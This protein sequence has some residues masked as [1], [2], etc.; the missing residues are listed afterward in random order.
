MWAL[1]GSA[2]LPFLEAW[3]FLSVLCIRTPNGHG[4]SLSKLQG[5]VLLDGAVLS[6]CLPISDQTTQEIRHV[7]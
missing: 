5:Q 3:L 2:A 1:T 7:A 4:I 6:L